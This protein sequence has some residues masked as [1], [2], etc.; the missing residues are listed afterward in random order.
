MSKNI[1]IVESDNDRLFIER[2]KQHIV[3][4]DFDIIP[5]ICNIT[6]YQYLDGLST[7]RLERKLQELERDL[8]QGI[9]N[10][11]GIL[12]DADNEGIEK[13]IELINK[14]IKSIDTELEIAEAN[15]WYK[16]ESLDAY[17]S[18]HILNVSGHGELETLL[19]TI[20]SQPSLYADCLEAWRNCVTTQN[21]KITDK[22]FDKFWV[23]IYQRYDCCNHKERKQAGTRCNSEAS[24]KK[25]IWD[26]SHPALND[27]KAYLGM[28]D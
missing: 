20:K 23:S 3:Q 14:A 24:F 17:F 11:I 18:C 28:F 15:T 8:N 4:T 10:K 22:E 2:L 9:L 16:S 7:A 13:R 19:K 5:P 25:D 27:L 21:Q 26:F 1:L 6:D 12:V